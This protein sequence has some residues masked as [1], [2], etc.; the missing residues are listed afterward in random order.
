MRNLIK[1]FLFVSFLLPGFAHA[2]GMLKLAAMYMAAKT[3]SGGT[4]SDSSRTLL[5]LNGA[6]LWPKGWAAGLLYGMDNQKAG[7]STLKRVSYGPS[8]GWVSRKENGAFVM[9]SY[10]FK[11]EYEDYEGTGYQADLG[12]KFTVRKIAIV[13]QFSYKAFNYDKINGQKLSPPLKETKLDPYFGLL[14]EF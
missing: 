4:T 5:D 2:D 10:L 6:Y 9:L 7:S 8:F 3:D 13:L 11:S 1:A 14:F 12:Y